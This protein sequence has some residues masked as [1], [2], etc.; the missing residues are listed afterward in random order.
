MVICILHSVWAFPLPLSSVGHRCT[1][2]CEGSSVLSQHPNSCNFPWAVAPRNATRSGPAP[3]GR[4]RAEVPLRL[5]SSPVPCG[6]SSRSPCHGTL[7]SWGLCSRGC[8]CPLERSRG[9]PV[10][11]PCETTTHIPS[12]L[13]TTCLTCPGL[14][15]ALSLGR[16][17]GAARRCPCC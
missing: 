2:V 14:W 15:S 8:S 17:W 10:K 11:S 9:L 4:G 5:F 6:E 7:T 16:L 1:C 3:L 13:L 12:K